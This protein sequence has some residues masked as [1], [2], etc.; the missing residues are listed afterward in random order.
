MQRDGQTE[1]QTDYDIDRVCIMWIHLCCR[2]ARQRVRGIAL[3]C[4][5]HLVLAA[6]RVQKGHTDCIAHAQVCMEARRFDAGKLSLYTQGAN[7]CFRRSMLNYTHANVTYTTQTVRTSPR[8]QSE[9]MPS[10]DP[11]SHASYGPAM[12]CKFLSFKG[13]SWCLRLSLSL[14]Q[15]PIHHWVFFCR[16]VFVRHQGLHQHPRR[17]SSECNTS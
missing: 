8:R 12:L 2:A 9:Q 14:S 5:T 13:W 4:S 6:C 17:R 11:W 7:P 10:A 16:A 1:R 3:S 15:V